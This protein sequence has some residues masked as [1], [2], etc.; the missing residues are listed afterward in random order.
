MGTTFHVHTEIRRPTAALGQ[1]VSRPVCRSIRRALSRGMALDQRHPVS[2]QG[3]GRSDTV[4]EIGMETVKSVS[5]GQQFETMSATDRCCAGRVP[6]SQIGVSSRCSR[7]RSWEDRSSRRFRRASASVNGRPSWRLSGGRFPAAPAGLS[8]TMPGTFAN[9]RSSDWPWIMRSVGESNSG[10][11][12]RAIL[13][14]GGRREG[15]GGRPG[16]ASA[17]RS[18]SISRRPGWTGTSPGRGAKRPSRQPT[19]RT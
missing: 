18:R 2:Y 14:A 15:S 19:R 4:G 5:K 11:R 12:I 7:E 13:T 1:T 17:V 6:Q 9:R 3:R 16:R 10:H 8:L